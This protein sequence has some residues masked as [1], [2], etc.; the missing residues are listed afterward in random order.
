MTA[1]SLVVDRNGVVYAGGLWTDASYWRHDSQGWTEA[2]RSAD[3]EGGRLVK[4]LGE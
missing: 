2:D 1:F 4:I 3:H